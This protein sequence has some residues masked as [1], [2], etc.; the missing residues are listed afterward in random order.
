MSSPPFMRAMSYR[1][2]PAVAPSLHSDF[3]IMACQPTMSDGCREA[4]SRSLAED[5]AASGV[6]A[7]LRLPGGRAA[8]AARPAPQASVRHRHLVDDEDDAVALVDV[9][10][11]DVGPMIPCN[12]ACQPTVPEIPSGRD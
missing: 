9:G 2:P 11:G 10:D 3:H 1:P 7:G 5:T 8:S 6:E 4:W 12:M